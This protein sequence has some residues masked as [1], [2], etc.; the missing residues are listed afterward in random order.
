MIRNAKLPDFGVQN[1]SRFAS[2]HG[3]RERLLFDI[4]YRHSEAEVSEMIERAFIDI[5]RQQCMG[6]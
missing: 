5:A 6:S 3:L 4:D 2:A 1:L